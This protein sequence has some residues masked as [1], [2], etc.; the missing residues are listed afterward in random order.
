[1]L[2]KNLRTHILELTKDRE[3]PITQEQYKALK[4]AQKIASYN[5][6]LEI[7]DPDT[8]KILHDGL[9]KDFVW[10]RELERSEHVGAS[11]I[12]DFWNRH[13]IHESCDCSDKYK[14]SP[15]IFRMKLAE[16]YPNIKYSRQITWKIRNEILN[17]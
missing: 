9:W 3:I 6:A 8:Q 1:M 4:N 13:P 16:K 11:I 5:D 7:H 14:I 17:P 10:F 15:I 12:C 2:T